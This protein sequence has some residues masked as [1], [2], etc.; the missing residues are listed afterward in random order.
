MLQVITGK[1]F[2]PVELYETLHRGVLYTNYQAAKDEPFELPIGRIL[3]STHG[4]RLTTF[5]YELT[6]KLEA[7][8]PDGG[9][10]A[11]ISTGGA[12]L[13][14][15]LAVALSFALNITC[16]PD[17]DLTLRLIGPS[18]AM[19]LV[20]ERPDSLIPRVFDKEIWGRQDDHDVVGAF[21]AKLLALDRKTYEA[22]VRA[23]RQYVLATHRVLEDLDL[24][25]ALIVMS[26][27]SLAQTFDG[28]KAGWSDYDEAKRTAIDRALADA[29]LATIGAVRAAILDNEH[30]AVSRRFR[31]FVQ[32]H[33]GPAF[34]RQ[35]AVGKSHPPASWDL[36]I[37]VRRA[38][39]FRSR[40]VHTLT[41]APRELWFLGR[42][43]ETL[44]LESGPALTMAGL[45]RLARHVIN[46]VIDRGQPVADEAYDYR[47]HLPNIIRA[48]MAPTHWL[49]SPDALKTVSAQGHLEA[50]LDQLVNRA[51]RTPGHQVMNLGP[52]LGEL[53][54][55]FSITKGAERRHYLLVYVLWHFATPQAH[56]RDDWRGV[57][58]TY[59]KD[60]TAP[61]AENLAVHL[62]VGQVPPW[63]LAVLESI[64]TR[65]MAAKGKA[66]VKLGRLVEAAITLAVAE[67]QRVVGDEVRARALISEAVEIFPGCE[68]L[69]Q[70]EK[71][72]AGHEVLAPIDW[73]PVLFP[74]AEGDAVETLELGGADVGDDTQIGPNGAA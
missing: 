19:R 42:G 20:H 30:V 66:R 73:G 51:L 57:L 48:R 53:E 17:Q 63:D 39:E 47:A 64:R 74:P 28:T 37:A 49:G 12:E 1:F 8:T 22:V 34:F 67:A 21:F 68:A 46:Q 59:D 23:M 3:P 50:F 62:L 36:P 13:T 7:V 40:Y 24:A 29:S 43:S 4:A 71:D 61:C 65:H 60:L 41:Q 6:E 69:T 56:H 44:E 55:R 2:R 26:I 32:N 14:G 11:M 15:D 10:E 16:T 45:A 54:A 33:V 5:T 72:V 52:I 9:M 31:D 58:D 70:L 35:E 38:Y 27:E 18:P 25:Y